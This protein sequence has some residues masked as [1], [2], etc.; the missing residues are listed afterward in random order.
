M[1]IAS[2]YFDKNTGRQDR[3]L[4]IFVEG[5]D[6]AHFVDVVLQD[7]GADPTKIGIIIVEGTP[8]FSN[9]IAMFKK[10]PYYRNAKGI[11]VIRDADD[12]VAV[13]IEDSNKIFS[14]EFQLQANHAQITSSE[15]FSVGL[16]V[17]PGNE[18]LGDLEKLCLA[19]VAGTPLEIDAEI[20]INK[21]KQFGILNKIHKRK[22]QVFLAGKPG[23]VC[24]GAGMGFKRGFF[25]KTHESL[26]P[27]KHFLVK[28]IALN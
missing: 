20:Y 28:F 2:I 13:A 19:T 10:S 16:F 22:A 24:R 14:K 25:D 23:D 3:P 11:V 8:Q 17:L 9:S 18:E 12:N 4:L 6:D 1:S 7:I 21:I 26:V 5:T 27:L 15:A